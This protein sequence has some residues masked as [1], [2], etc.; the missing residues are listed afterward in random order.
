[1]FAFLFKVT[2]FTSSLV[3][4]CWK[5]PTENRLR[6]K[7]GILWLSISAVTATVSPW[8]AAV[9]SLHP[10]HRPL[11]LQL[12][13]PSRFLKE[14]LCC[15]SQ[16]SAESTLKIAFTAEIEPQSMNIHGWCSWSTR[17][18]SSDR[19][20]PRNVKAARS[21]SLFHSKQQKRFPLRGR[22]DQQALRLDR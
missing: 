19:F 8:S 9:T 21:F 2:A 10:R 6:L 20:F 22:F 12:P 13:L 4:L 17:N 15:R 11:L 14:T 3:R 5:S 1:M 18:V 7:T 16:A